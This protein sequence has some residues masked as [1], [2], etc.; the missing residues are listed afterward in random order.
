MEA[1]KITAGIVGLFLVFYVA[2]LL[3]GGLEVIVQCG[4]YDSAQC[5]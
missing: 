1:L 3:V 2:G 4:V 5:E